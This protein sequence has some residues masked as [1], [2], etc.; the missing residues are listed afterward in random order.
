MPFTLTD[1]QYSVALTLSRAGA[2]SAEDKRKIQDF[3]S[4]IEKANNV[5]RYMLLVRW[6]NAGE[7]F[8]PGAGMNF[9]RVWPETNQFIMETFERPISKTD[10][11]EMLKTRSNAP[12]NVMVTPDVAGLVGWTL[13]DAYFV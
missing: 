3:F 9:P 5:T 7:K 1:E 4:T 8:A 2:V 13:L 11:L 6:Q 12:T 10:V